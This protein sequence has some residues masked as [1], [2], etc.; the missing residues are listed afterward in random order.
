MS[1]GIK[2]VGREL[3]ALGA[4]SRSEIAARLHAEG[5]KGPQLSASQCPVARYLRLHCDVDVA[6]TTTCAFIHEDACE[7]FA[8]LPTSVCDFIVN[9]D[10]CAYPDL[11]QPVTT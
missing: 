6:V 9:F 7:R 1:K 11:V 5:V 2:C 10:R 8:R 4:L 3:D